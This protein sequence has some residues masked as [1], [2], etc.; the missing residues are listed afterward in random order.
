M[1]L[2]EWVARSVKPGCVKTCS[3]DK[4]TNQIFW[5]MPEKF[6]SESNVSSSLESRRLLALTLHF[7]PLSYK[8]SI[9]SSSRNHALTCCP[10]NIHFLH[11]YSAQCHSVTAVTLNCNRIKAT[12]A[13]KVPHSTNKPN[14]SMHATIIT[15]QGYPSIKTSLLSLIVFFAVRS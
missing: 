13:I 2:T 1:T 15:W 10:S 11:F 14:N 7:H 5:E 9:R 12:C 4:Y 3:D 6:T 8:C